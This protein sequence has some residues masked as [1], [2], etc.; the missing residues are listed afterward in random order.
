MKSVFQRKLIVLAFYIFLTAVLFLATFSVFIHAKSS[1]FN[2]MAPLNDFVLYQS[3]SIIPLGTDGLSPSF[4][5]RFLPKGTDSDYAIFYIETS[6]GGTIKGFTGPFTDSK[7]TPIS[8]RHQ[9]LNLGLGS[10]TI[11]KN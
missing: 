2:F 8:V 3:Y 4:V 7:S 6:L 1:A 10:N 11:S 5:F 9:M